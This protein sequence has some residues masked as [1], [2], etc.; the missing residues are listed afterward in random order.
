M[1][2]KKAPH[3]AFRVHISRNQG[4][5][6][7]HTIHIVRDAAPSEQRAMFYTAIMGYDAHC[8]DGPGDTDH[9]FMP[10]KKPEPK[11]EETSHG[12]VYYAGHAEWD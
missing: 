3:A 7:S 5:G 8:A 4:R 1:M 11:I 10:P 12:T 2:Y 9:K 6:E